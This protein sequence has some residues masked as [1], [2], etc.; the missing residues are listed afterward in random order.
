MEGSTREGFDMADNPLEQQFANALKIA[1]R[2]NLSEKLPYLA[3]TVA[4]ANA[5]KP[6][7][8]RNRVL[9]TVIE[10]ITAYEQSKAAMPFLP[11]LLQPSGTFAPL[12]EKSRGL[13]LLL[14]PVDLA[15]HTLISGTTGSAKTTG[16]KHLVAGVQLADPTVIVDYVDPNNDFKNQALRD[17][18][19]LL[20]TDETPL[21]ITA[22]PSFLRPEYFEQVLAKIFAESFYGASHMTR[23]LTEVMRQRRAAQPNGYSLKDLRDAID[24]TT[25]KTLSFQ[26]RDAR[27]SII[28]R[29]DLI[30]ATQRG[31]YTATRQNG[32]TLEQL[33]DRPTW[34]TIRSRLSSDEFQIALWLQVLIDY[35]RHHHL[36][37]LRRLIVM[38]EGLTFWQAESKHHISGNPLFEHAFSQ[39]RSKGIGFIVT[40]TSLRAVSSVIKANTN[41]Q[42]TMRL[43]D[44]S[45]VEEAKR[46]LRLNQEQAAYLHDKL[47][48]GECLVRMSHKYPEPLLCT[49][50]RIDE[51]TITN[52]EWETAARERADA[53]LP[54]PTVKVQ[55][56]DKVIPEPIPQPEEANEDIALN[57][58]DEALLRHIATVTITTVSE[59]YDAIGAHSGVADDAKQRLLQLGYLTATKI[60]VH[61]RRGGTAVGLE[62]T[63][64][65]YARAD[66]KPS[67]R[68]RGGKAQAEFIIQ[69]LSKL[70][71]A[72]LEVNLGGKAPDLLLRIDS[73][74]H[75]DFLLALNDHAHTFTGDTATIPPKSLLAIEVEVSDYAKTVRNNLT[76]DRAAGLQH[77]LFA[78]M[79]KDVQLVVQHLIST[80][81]NLNGV[82]VINALRLLDT[83]RTTSSGEQSPDRSPTKGAPPSC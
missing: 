35:H 18:R 15:S 11:R 9:Q 62:V 65:G 7:L 67:R 49:F 36:T 81:E 75:R 23:L 38:D 61:D 37:G 22:C 43:V 16:A 44:G 34:R 76:K 56:K 70:L 27:T 24:R 60:K 17:Q 8:L 45:E 32:I 71:G 69:R 20:I 12:T 79:P 39:T 28:G 59:A 72:H 77:I 5:T 29:L 50:P 55:E 3:L 2:E 26:E 33:C 48:R 4:S 57:T 19:C 64:E 25:T 53:I 58:T 66:I 51:P 14:D 54:T 63:P 42:I 31:T 82:L 6:G 52:E 47:T 46:T 1:E 68:S 30:A 73:V 21:C 74:Q 78:V 41:F 80:G 13:P 10:Q 83:L 40:T